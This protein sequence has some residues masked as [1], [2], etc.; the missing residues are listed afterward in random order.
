MATQNQNGAPAATASAA[1]N[2]LIL[3]NAND[4]L[5]ALHALRALKYWKNTSTSQNVSESM[6]A[7]EICSSSFQQGFD[8]TTNWNGKSYDRKEIL[9]GFGYLRQI[10]G[11]NLDSCA[12][13]SE[14]EIKSAFNDYKTAQQKIAGSY[15]SNGADKGTYQKAEEHYNENLK[16]NKKSKR[17]IRWARFGRVALWIATLGVVGGFFGSLI[18]I[19]GGLAALMG[20]TGLLFTAVVGGSILFYVGKKLVS[21]LDK[22][23]SGVINRNKK[24]VKGDEDVFGSKKSLNRASE[25]LN[26]QERGAQKARQS[27]QAAN[28]LDIFFDQIPSSFVNGNGNAQQRGNINGNAW[29]NSQ[30]P[31]AP[32]YTQPQ[33]QQPVASPQPVAGQRVQ[34][35]GQSVQQPVQPVQQQP[36]N[37]QSAQQAYQPQENHSVQNKY[38]QTTEQDVP[39]NVSGVLPNFLDESIKQSYRKY[40][41][42][43][44]KEKENDERI[45]RGRE[46]YEEQE[47]AKKVKKE[48]PPVEYLFG[49]KK[50]ADEFYDEHF[51]GE[52]EATREKAEFKKFHTKYNQLL[53]SVVN[54]VKSDAASKAK[55]EN[56]EVSKED[57]TKGKKAA[58]QKFLQKLE[59]I[60]TLKN[61]EVDELW[62]LFA[63]KIKYNNRYIAAEEKTTEEKRAI[64]EQ[65]AK[66]RGGENVLSNPLYDMLADDKYTVGVGKRVTAKKGLAEV[67]EKNPEV[68]GE[69]KVVTPEVETVVDTSAAATEVTGNP[70]EKNSNGGYDKLNNVP[71]RSPWWWEKKSLRSLLF[72]LF[73]SAQGQRKDNKAAKKATEEKF[74]SNTSAAAPEARA[75]KENGSE[76]FD[77]AK[78]DAEIQKMLNEAGL[79]DVKF[80]DIHKLVK[81][82][83]AK[84]TDSKKN[85]DDYTAEN[86]T[87]DVRDTLEGTSG[88]FSWGK[89]GEGYKNFATACKL[90]SEEENLKEEDIKN[91]KS[92]LNGS[93]LIQIFQN[94]KL[95][96]IAPEPGAE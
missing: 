30:Q 4:Y 29:Q 38:S 11:K 37:Q 59:D 49:D 9:D 87:K 40:L 51:S 24:I 23:L 90:L 43:Y 42:E 26:Q 65:V 20:E 36:V 71:G 56:S 72:S 91:L 94:A 21:F 76:T 35:Q 10:T 68:T 8:T 22:K 62:K 57:L 41:E 46:E 50:A 74:V 58:E 67:V 92:I 84:A 12:N 1:P 83:V 52:D 19:A 82:A 28:N 6:V 69:P 45:K 93:N 18:G 2:S 47:R 7:D 53:T 61:E 60:S 39:Y 89:G 5:V 44:D 96:E 63:S 70:K 3:K 54:S 88:S 66:S 33:G 32:Q 80:S 15:S 81:A 86:F 27:I 55:E 13:V 85:T 17:K 31:V 64:L 16:E 73:P 95:K 48:K 14:A 75:Q 77:T 25:L 34:P 79:V 78:V